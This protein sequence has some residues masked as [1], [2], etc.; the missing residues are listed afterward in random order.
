[1][2]NFANTQVY[3][4]L[5]DQ[6]IKRAKLLGIIYYSEDIKAIRIFHEMID[7]LDSSSRQF[8]TGNEHI[9]GIYLIKV[10]VKFLVK[11]DIG[12]CVFND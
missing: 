9:D 10:L 2:I 3:V 7:R 1:M 12:S 4:M 11:L 6:A 8:A 5:R